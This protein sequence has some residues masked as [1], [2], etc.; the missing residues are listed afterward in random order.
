[1]PLRDAER[2]EEILDGEVF[3]RIYSELEQPLQISS[4]ILG[5]KVA[6]PERVAVALANHGIDVENI[7]LSKIPYR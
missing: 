3:P 4:V 6:A 2:T 1:M 7:Y 5:P